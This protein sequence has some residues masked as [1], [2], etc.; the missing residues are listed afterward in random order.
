MEVLVRLWRPQDAC[1][2]AKKLL[3]DQPQNLKARALY[4][5]TLMNIGEFEEALLEYSRGQIVRK[6]PPYFMNGYLTV[7]HSKITY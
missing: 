7:S 6:Q 5:E 1:D 4:A 2:L 3:E